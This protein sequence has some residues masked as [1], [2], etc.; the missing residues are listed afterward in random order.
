[1]AAAGALIGGR[2]ECSNAA[3]PARQRRLLPSAAPGSQV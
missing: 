2:R 3:P 1:M